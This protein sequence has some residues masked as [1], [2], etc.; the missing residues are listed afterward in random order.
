MADVISI[1]DRFA[2][3]T[4]R[5]SEELPREGRILMFTGVRYERL[6]RSETPDRTSGDKSP[7]RRTG[8]KAKKG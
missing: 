8:T 2:R 6:V 7:P 5:R 3:P 1:A 4:T